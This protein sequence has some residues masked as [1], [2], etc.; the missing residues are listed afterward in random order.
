[1]RLVKQVQLK[2][3]KILTDLCVRSKNLFNSANYVI[4]W[5]FFNTGR[6][7]RYTELYERLRHH[8]AYKS[9]KE[10]AGSHAPQQ[11]LKTLDKS[12]KSFFNAIKARKS[13]TN[14]PKPNMPKYK[15]KKGKHLVIWTKLQSRVKNNEFLLTKKL[16]LKGFKE[17]PLENTPITKDNYIGARLVPYC[18][19]YIFEIIYEKEIVDLELTEDNIAGLDLGVSNLVA[20]SNNIG[21]K[22]MIIK[23]GVVKSVNQYYNKQVAY[24]KLPIDYNDYTALE[25]IKSRTYSIKLQEK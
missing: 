20:M 18:D 12:W 6:W 4:R 19:R 10:L 1:M 13:K 3:S 9:F 24:Y 11:L 15:P 8:E 5:H 2:P 25:I 21:L 7:V 23:G 14:N 16:I 22:P 17:I